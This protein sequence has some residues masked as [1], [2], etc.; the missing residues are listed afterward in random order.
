MHGFLGAATFQWINP[1]SWLVSASAAGTFLDPQAGSAV[2]QAIALGG[3]FVLAALPSGFV[4]L[5]F[6]ASAQRLL[7]TERRLRVFN[8]AMAA[9]LALSVV[10]LL[11][12][13]LLAQIRDRF[14]GHA[15]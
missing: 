8:L 3:V 5:A 9:L 11:D 2:V 7:R 4:W 12:D 14:R 13:A 15:E 1:K 10:L 6:G